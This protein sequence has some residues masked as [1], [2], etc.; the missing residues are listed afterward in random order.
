M[1]NSTHY[2]R[3]SI[4]KQSYK[5]LPHTSHDLTCTISNPHPLIMCQTPQHGSN[6][7]DNEA[8]AIVQMADT[9]C[10]PTTT[11]VKAGDGTFLLFLLS[12]TMIS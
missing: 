9:F 4:A 10:D 11:T 7:P 1:L 12:T 5:S 8:V 2:Y 6:H 3:Y